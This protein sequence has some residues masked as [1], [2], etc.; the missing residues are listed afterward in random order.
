MKADILFA[1]LFLNFLNSLSAQELEFN[2]NC[3]EAYL[4][5]IALRFDEGRDL[6][7]IE[8]DANPDNRIPL[9]LENYIDFLTVFISEDMAI[10]DQLKQNK[11]ER[12]RLIGL[13]QDTSPYKNWA[14][15]MINMQ[16]AFARLK[17]GEQFAA[18]LEIRRAFLLLEENNKKFP[19]FMQNKIG[20]GLLQTLIGSIPPQYQWVARLASM[21]GTVH[22]GRNNLLDVIE[23]SDLDPYTA[24][25]KYESLFFL[26]FIEMNLMADKSDFDFLIRSIGDKDTSNLLMSYIKANLLKKNAKNDLA[27][28]ILKRRPKS[29]NFYPFH[30]LDYLLAEAYLSKLQTELSSHYYQLFLDHFNGINYKQDAL[31]KLAWI[32]LLDDDMTGYVEYMDMVKSIDGGLVDADKQALREA[33]QGIPPQV[34]LLKAR[35]LFDGGYHEK[36]LDHLIHAQSVLTANDYLEYHYRLGRIYHEMKF[37]DDATLHY[38]KT[39]NLGAAN[40]AYYAA[41]AALKLGEIFEKQGNIEQAEACFNKCLGMK[42][43]E[44]RSSIQQ[45]ARAGISRLA[46]YKK[47]R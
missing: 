22:E 31:R 42:P 44:Y 46:T 40:P 34:D 13:A 39:I 3:R 15:A 16:W 41:N 43:E 45:K 17:F 36:A 2:Q 5:V 4:H 20:L 11:T 28:Q 29:T 35:L 7:E 14:L 38:N 26:S 24:H 33:N 37:Y 25:L 12:L 47:K 10:F 9:V 30:Y 6:L 21:H 23:R 8:L 27:I 1:F 18:A 19:Y 32:K